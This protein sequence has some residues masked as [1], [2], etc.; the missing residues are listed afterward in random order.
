MPSSILT[1]ALFAA[2]TALAPVRAPMDPPLGRADA[3]VDLATREGTALVKATWRYH[4][5]DL[6]SIEGRAPGPD[7]KA[8]S[9]WKK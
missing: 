2:V 9:P 7:L 6:V 1:A 3:V 4:D 8:S 5:A